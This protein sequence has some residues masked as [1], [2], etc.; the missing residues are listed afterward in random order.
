MTAILRNRYFAL[1]HGISVA[2]E[3]GIIVSHPGNGINACGL[4]PRGIEECRRRLQPEQLAPLAF[5]R[6]DTAVYTSDFRRAMETA[7]IFCELN[8]LDAPIADSRLRERN[9]GSLEGKSIGAYDRVWALDESDEDNHYEGC[10]STAAL[11]A[12]LTELLADLEARWHSKSIVLVSHGDP[13]QVLQ[14]IVLGL[15]CNQHR[16]LP[17]L[18]NAEMRE[19]R[20]SNFSTPLVCS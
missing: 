7:W 18:E 2:N 19:I 9:F 4:S 11:A 1:R 17:H 10:E 16:S 8:A 13:L 14:A 5:E 12:R 3:E 6:Q 15:P 20:N